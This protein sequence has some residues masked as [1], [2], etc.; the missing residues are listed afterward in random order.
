[1]AD[2]TLLPADAHPTAVRLQV[3]NLQRSLHW[4]QS[5]IGC[6]PLEV[7]SSSAMLGAHGTGAR[8][9]I[10]LVERPGARA[11]RPHARLGL[12][13]F[14]I[15]LPSR[16]ALGAFVRR[17]AA[18]DVRVGS[19]DH[20]VSEAL[21]MSDPD[22]LGIEVYADRP[23]E[24]W[25]WQGEQVVMTVDHLDFR[26]LARAAVEPWDGLPA[27]TT[28]GH[29]HL[30]VG[31]LDEALAFYQQ[32][33][34]FEETARLPG[35]AFLA[36][37]RYHHHLG[38]NIWAAGA[39]S[40]HD[41]DAQLLEWTLTVPDRAAAAAAAERLTQAGHAVRHDD[42]ADRGWTVADP[43]GTRLRVLS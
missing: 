38:T 2:T 31:G 23:R 22:G 11:V 32:G 19:A 6:R 8:P 21:Y 20:L 26:D 27:G 18:L 10:E 37:G 7:T 39:P 43:W 42:D 36:A 4:Y 1:M 13:H 25:T 5:I 34:G 15:L 35:A 17:L 40:P 12:Y 30:H 9:L 3:S 33:L 24:T 29:V 14:A 16:A 41:D 28:I